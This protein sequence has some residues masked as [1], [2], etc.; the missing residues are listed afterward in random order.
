MMVISFV[1]VAPHE[2][3]LPLHRRIS[4]RSGVHPAVDCQVGT[5]DERGL[6]A[7][8]EGNKRGNLVHVSIPIQRNDRLLAYGPLARGGVQI[9][10]NGP[11]LDIVDRDPPY[12]EFTRQ[13][14]R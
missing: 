13:P 12:S 2:W 6:R 10:V 3:S 14:L 5:G 9:G 7:G 1:G 4:L 11:R 8:D